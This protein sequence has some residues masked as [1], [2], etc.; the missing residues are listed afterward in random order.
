MTDDLAWKAHR[1]LYDQGAQGSIERL[2]ECSEP[3][4][5]TVGAKEWYNAFD[6]GKDKPLRANL[7][8][9]LEEENLN[10]VRYLEVK[11]LYWNDINSGNTYEFVFVKKNTWIESNHDDGTGEFRLYFN[12]ELVLIAEQYAEI[13]RWDKISSVKM[14]SWIKDIVRIEELESL[15][16]CELEWHDKNLEDL[17]KNNEMSD[18]FDFGEFG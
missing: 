7:L 18:K 1:I 4:F 14:T 17:S 15:A 8:K 12:A 11:D 3:Q 13:I 6:T 5:V 2:V 9:S 10:L 16:Q